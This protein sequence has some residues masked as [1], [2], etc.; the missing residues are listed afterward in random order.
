MSV[1]SADE[2]INDIAEVLREADADFIL[3]IADQVLAWPV[4][5]LGDSQ[6]KVANED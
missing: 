1:R 4:T 2:I 5:Y 3:E 6:F